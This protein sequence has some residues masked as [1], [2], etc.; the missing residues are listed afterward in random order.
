M[1]PREMRIG[2][3][4]S[5]Y[6]FT[7]SFETLASQLRTNT[8]DRLITLDGGPHTFWWPTQNSDGS[9]LPEDIP[10]PQII[11]EMQPNAKFIITLSDPVKRLYS[12]YY[13]LLDNLK[14]VKAGSETQKCADELHERV[15]MQI[16]E[17]QYCLD[18]NMDILINEQSHRYKKLDK[19]Q[20]SL[21]WLRASQICAHDRRKFGKGGW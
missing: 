15:E 19:S 18:K 6:S 5:V 8:N 1:S 17:F 7:R 4:S 21:L 10:A 12:D 11:R 16:N 9:M 14:P 20:G 2:P 3:G 13:F